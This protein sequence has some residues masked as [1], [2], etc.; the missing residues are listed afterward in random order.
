MFTIAGCALSL[1]SG[2]L[3]GGTDRI[4]ARDSRRFHD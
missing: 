1:V 3:R 4:T 2:L